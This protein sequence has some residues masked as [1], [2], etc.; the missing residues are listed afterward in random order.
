MYN[1]VRNAMDSNEMVSKFGPVNWGPELMTLGALN[2][3]LAALSMI[4]P[5]GRCYRTVY[6]GSII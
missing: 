2:G 5:Y 6:Q 1:D 4:P 3:N